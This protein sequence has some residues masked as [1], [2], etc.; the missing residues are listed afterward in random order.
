L[1]EVISNWDPPQAAAALQRAAESLTLLRSQIAPD[2]LPL[3][4]RYLSTLQDYLNNIRPESAA[5]YAKNA[6]SQLAV[7]RSSTCSQ[8]SKLDAERE[9]LRSRYV[10]APA[11]AQLNVRAES[12]TH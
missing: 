12:P 6:A 1:Q 3:L 11:A 2:L 7:L 8:L 5:W 9:S 10:A 4:D